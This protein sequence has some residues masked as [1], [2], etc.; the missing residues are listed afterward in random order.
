MVDKAE[1]LEVTNG[2]EHN[3]LGKVVTKIFTKT[4]MR[5]TMFVLGIVLVILLS[6]AQFAID[7]FDID[8]ATWGSNLLLLTGILI[9]FMVLGEGFKD[10]I[11]TQPEGLYQQ[12][13]KTYR[14]TRESISDITTYFV[15][16][17]SYKRERELKEKIIQTLL[18]YGIIQANGIV[19][20]LNSEEIENLD[21]KPVEKNGIEFLKVS[22]K[23]KEII[24]DVMKNTTLGITTPVYYLSEY[25]GYSV[26]SDQ[27]IPEVLEKKRKLFKWSGRILRVL[28]SVTISMLF[29][30]FTVNDFMN[31]DDMQAWYNLLSRIFTAFSGLL[32]GYLMAWGL[33]QFDI[34]EFQ[35]KTRFLHDF[36]L[37]FDREIFKPINRHDLFLKQK[38]E[39]EKEEEKRRAETEI[40]TKEE[41]DAIQVLKNMGDT[42]PQIE[43]KPVIKL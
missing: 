14:I 19:N 2:G 1:N 15:E 18:N 22:K 28:G 32:S 17:H 10:Y 30:A 29:A 41:Y 39:A 23:Q 21:R 36:R 4:T 31:G 8:W 5:L 26:V 27:D 13:L 9:I 34:R 33:N 37:E 42:P 24:V 20:N 16:Y 7:F 12:S 6:V 35:H 3:K 11:R 40:L 38:E 43:E 25:E